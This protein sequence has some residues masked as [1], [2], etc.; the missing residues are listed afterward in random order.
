MKHPAL[1]KGYSVIELVVYISLFVLISLVVVQSLLYSMKTYS[2]ARAYRT[3]QRNAETSLNRITSEIRQS[4]DVSAGSVFGS[5][6]GTLVLTGTDSGGAPYTSTISVSNGVIQI[7]TGGV[8]TALTSVEE[9]VSD[10]T[11]WHIVTSTTDAIK[12]EVTYTTVREP[13]ITRTF[14]TTVVLRE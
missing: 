4:S 9:S 14:Y 11:F 5:T 6:P 13:V 2:I 1:T 7:V 3:L 10:L 8:T 12:L